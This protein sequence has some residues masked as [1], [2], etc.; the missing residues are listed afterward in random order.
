MPH[1][2][3]KSEQQTGILPLHL[4][5]VHK[6]GVPYS[7]EAGGIQNFAYDMPVE[8]GS[9]KVVTT[10]KWNMGTDG[11]KKIDPPKVP[12]CLI[13]CTGRPTEHSD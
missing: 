13:Q 1:A 6:K 3:G 2:T 9:P 8:T 5:L 7:P 4:I 10:E 12:S 11:N